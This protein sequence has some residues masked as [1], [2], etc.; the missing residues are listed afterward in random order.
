M[1]RTEP[2]G[3][4]ATWINVPNTLKKRGNVVL[5][6]PHEKNAIILKSLRV[7]VVVE[8][9]VEVEVVVVV[10]RKPRLKLGNVN[11]MEL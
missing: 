11:C 10:V 4:N 1:Y 5:M 3:N 7:W 2:N 9:V 6:V 8:V